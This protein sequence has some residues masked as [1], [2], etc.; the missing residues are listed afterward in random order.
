MSMYRLI[1]K[2]NFVFMNNPFKNRVEY[3]SSLVEPSLNMFTSNSVHYLS[4]SLL[5]SGSQVEWNG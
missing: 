3:S 1:I 5:A 2:S 4:F